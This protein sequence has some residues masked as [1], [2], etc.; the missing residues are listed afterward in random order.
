MTKGRVPPVAN[1][2]NSYAMVA[3]IFKKGLSP[4]E[5]NRYSS[6]LQGS[7]SG[8]N[9]AR[10]AVFEGANSL[11]YGFPFH[12][13][14]ST[15]ELFTGGEACVL[16][17][18]AASEVGNP[19]P[20]AVMSQMGGAWALA[21]VNDMEGVS[22]GRDIAGAQTMY[23][24]QINEAFYFSSSLTLFRG[25]GLEI[26][27]DAVT[28]FLH[29]LYVPA[30]RTIYRRVRAILPAQAVFWDGISL[31]K[32]SLPRKNFTTQSAISLPAE[33]E[34]SL[35]SEYETLLRQSVG[36]CVSRKGK[37]GLF[38]SGGKDSS[39]I[40]IAAR[41]EEVQ[42]FETFCIGFDES[43]IDETRDAEIVANHLGFPFCS[44]KFPLDTYLDHFPRFVAI[45]G[46]PIGDCAALPVYVGARETEGLYD[47]W[48]DGT[49]ND[50]YFGFPTT[51]QE[52]A[53]WYLHRTIPGLHRFPFARLPGD[54]SYSLDVIVRYLGKPRQEQ[55]VSWYGWTPVE[56]EELIGCR[57]NLKDLEL[58]SFY[59]KVSS[60]IIHKTWTLGN[61][62]EP[63]TAYRKV[64]QVANV[65][66]QL[67]RYPFLDK[68]LVAFSE[69]LPD[70]LKYDGAVNKIII[71]KVLEKYLP[72]SI[73]KKKKGAFNFPKGRLMTHRDN[74]LLRTFLSRECLLKHNVVDPLVVQKYLNRYAQGET[75][76]ED[77]IWSLV[78]LHAWA[79]ICAN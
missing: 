46:Q 66:G 73:V 32:F 1:D 30:P 34:A 72:K 6:A 78:L 22:L 65:L 33:T 19:S 14:S 53:A 3:G 13:T 15:S 21:E 44:L 56:L 40:A 7:F 43:E 47:V 64:A 71:R 68:E 79:E 24:G 36:R 51:W 29:F 67:V 9:P 26:D 25:I 5:K 48:L 18:H 16:V 75:I 62:W 17:F 35:L 59:H 69:N 39:S 70:S 55:F 4:E 63:E 74:Q 2:L 10:C 52:D 28:D 41:L 77:R 50:R 23:Y 61:I 54:L 76:L 12:G 20:L 45:H 11:I 38:L 37:T 58:Y 8:Q 27:R 60:P 31:K 57:P 42:D 49:G